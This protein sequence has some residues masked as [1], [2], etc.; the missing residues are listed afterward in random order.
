MAAPLNT[1]TTKEQRG[2]VRFLWAKNMEAKDIHIQEMLPIW[3][4]SIS[5]M[6]ISF[7]LNR[8][9][10]KMNHRKRNA[11]PWTVVRLFGDRDQRGVLVDKTQNG[12]GKF[13]RV[14]AMMASGEVVV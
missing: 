13:V 12:G 3:D 10:S 4:G 14:H 1:C 5:C 7:E 8:P 9:R 6:W 2:V 11:K